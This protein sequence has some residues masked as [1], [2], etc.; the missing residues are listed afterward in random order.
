MGAILDTMEHRSS[1]TRAAPRTWLWLQF[2]LAVSITLMLNQKPVVASMSSS[3]NKAGDHVTKVSP[4]EHSA[5]PSKASSNLDSFN[6]TRYQ[7]QSKQNER[8][9][10]CEGKDHDQDKCES[11]GCCSW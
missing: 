6:R 3:P 11:F 9:E 2:T 10:V 7:R 8:E 4:F 5:P 1:R